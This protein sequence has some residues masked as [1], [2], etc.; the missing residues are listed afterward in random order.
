MSFTHLHLHTSYSLLD[1]AGKISEMVDRAKALGQDSIAI[2][3]HGVMYG[4]VEFF[5]TCLKKGLKPIIG[6][7]I[8]VVEGSRFDRRSDEERYHLILLS[9]N[10]VG[11][12]NL[13]KIVS[14]GF[15]DGFYYKPRVDYEILNK[16]HEGLICL[17]A[18]VQGEVPQALL[19]GQYGEA[20]LRAE[21]LKNI[22]GANNLFIEIQNHGLKDELMIQPD[23]IRIA[24]EIGVKVV[25]TNDCHYTLKEDSYA[26]DCL[27]ALQTGKKVN[28]PNRGM[29]YE[30]EKYYI[31]SED[32]MKELFKFCPE[33]VE[34]TKLIAD[35]C[36]IKISF[37]QTA[38]NE[39][40]SNID[41]LKDS[42]NNSCDI[43]KLKSMVGFSEYHV[44]TFDVPKG[45]TNVEYL[46]KL[47]N[48]GLER[49][50]DL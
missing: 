21:N 36:N 32:E 44:P 23:L 12:K 42:K 29:K 6:S 37:T 39:L 18:C 17:T 40:M 20:K 16:Y 10:E 50:Y 11:Y 14:A 27:I 3:D 5:K 47:A 1:G 35:R 24:D 48:E 45:F 38:Y 7:E 4:A 49:K 9:E 25:A 15:V 8:Y 13:I 43:E 31:T 19:K 30:K 41:F 28:D 34:N 22:F 2:T 46:T 26:H 33:A